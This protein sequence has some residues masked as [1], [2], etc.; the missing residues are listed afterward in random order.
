VIKLFNGYCVS[1]NG[2][3]LGLKKIWKTDSIDGVQTVKHQHHRV[4]SSSSRSSVSC[5]S[6]GRLLCSVN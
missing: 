1:E 2:R 3:R 4:S 6:R 5:L